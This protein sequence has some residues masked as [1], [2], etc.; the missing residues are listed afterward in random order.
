MS[1]NVLGT[2]RYIPKK[3][4]TNDDL[5]EIVDTSDDWIRTRVGVVRRHVAVTETTADMACA[6]AEEALADSG[7]TAE[8][9]DLILVSTVSGDFVSPS[10]ACI[11]QK[12]LGA[13]CMA[14]DI[15]AA[16]AAFL[17]LLETAAGYFARGAVKKVLVIGAERMSKIV[18][19]HDRSTCV[20]FGDGAGAAVLGEGN[21]YGNAVFHVSGNDSVIRIPH[22]SGN[23]PFSTLEAEKPFIQMNGQETFKYAVTA[24]SHDIHEVLEH[25]QITADDVKYI[26][27]HQ[28]NNRIID[29]AARKSGIAADKFYRNIEE[30]GNTSSASIPIALDELNRQEKLAQG[31]ILLLTAF[32]GGLASAACLLRWSC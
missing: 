12:R 4:V 22:F 20:I 29:A 27:P 26:I 2:G 1:F 17:F 32:G 18:D 8:E 31:D 28:A 9:L 7:C 6:A 5:A 19:W 30:Y 24:M 13:H 10:T 15:N 14:Y 11:V 21:G 3:I 23:S 16:C 25:A